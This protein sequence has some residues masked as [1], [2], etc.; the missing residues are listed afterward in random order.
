MKMFSILSILSLVLLS[1]CSQGPLD[2]STRLLEEAAQ[3]I[4][5]LETQLASEREVFAE[6]SERF[7]TEQSASRKQVAELDQRIVDMQ[8]EVEELKRSSMALQGY[9]TIL[10]QR[11]DIIRETELK[12]ELQKQLREQSTE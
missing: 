9:L 11:L 8:S 5:E 2:D 10:Q 6:L 7:K 3:R 4:E 12:A 1:A